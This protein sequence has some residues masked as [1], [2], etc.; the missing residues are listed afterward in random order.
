MTEL[1]AGALAELP[2]MQARAAARLDGEGAAPRAERRTEVVLL[3]FHRA[4]PSD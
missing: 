3:H 2:A 4:A 1:L